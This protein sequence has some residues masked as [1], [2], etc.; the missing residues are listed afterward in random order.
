MQVSEQRC[1]VASFARPLA[2]DYMLREV[3]RMLILS[4][5]LLAGVLSLSCLGRNDCWLAWAGLT[6]CQLSAIQS[7]VQLLGSLASA[8]ARKMVNTLGG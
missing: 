3:L 4:E 2:L 8:R 1:P 5:R 6:R 7:L